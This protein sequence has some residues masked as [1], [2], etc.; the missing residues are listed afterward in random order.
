MSQQKQEIAKIKMYFDGLDINRSG[1]I[2]AEELMVPLISLG[3]VKS[4]HEVERLLKLV[5]RD[6]SGAIEFSEFLNI[7]L[8]K[9][10]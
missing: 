9:K 7:I 1:A 3:L 4:T 8:K 2:D 6:A 5:D 10:R